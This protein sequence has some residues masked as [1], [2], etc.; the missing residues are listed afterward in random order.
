MGKRLTAYANVVNKV[1][2]PTCTN[3]RKFL[4]FM[5]IAL[6]WPVKLM[7]DSSYHYVLPSRFFYQLMYLQDC[8]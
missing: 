1:K 4:F 8:I 6:G 2:F 3:I 5:T 7:F